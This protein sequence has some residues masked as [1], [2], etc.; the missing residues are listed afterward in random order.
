MKEEAVSKVRQPFFLCF[1]H[2]HYYTL[3]IG[4]GSFNKIVF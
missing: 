2:L 3:E 4:A 1:N